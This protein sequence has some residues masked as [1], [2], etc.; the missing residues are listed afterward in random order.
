MTAELSL[1]IYSLGVTPLRSL[2]ISPV[3]HLFGLSSVAPGTGRQLLSSTPL[4]DASTR[5]YKPVAWTGSSPLLALTCRLVRL[6]T[7]RS[8]E[9]S[10]NICKR[11]LLHLAV[12]D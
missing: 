6:Y 12:V 7:Y 5:L 1:V 11:F 2:M 8:T 4:P 10:M 9:M 3:R